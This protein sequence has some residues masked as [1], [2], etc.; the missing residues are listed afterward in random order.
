MYDTIVVPLDGS[1]LAEQVLPYVK[2][3][4]Q[5]RATTIHLVSIAPL[6]PVVTAAASPVRLYPLVVSAA[7]GVVVE[8]GWDKDLGHFI[9]I[10]HDF[11]VETVYGHL[12]RSFVKTGDQARKGSALGLVGSTGRS[13]GPHLHFEIIFKGKSVD[14]LPFLP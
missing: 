2:D 4:V 5:H 14:P 10:N 7:K 12:G 9:R 8:A 1:S 6:A 13:L 3:M 11:Q